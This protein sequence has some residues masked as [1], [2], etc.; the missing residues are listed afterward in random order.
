MQSAARAALNQFRALVARRGRAAATAGTLPVAAR[1]RHLSTTTTTGAKGSW[2]PLDERAVVDRG[3]AADDDVEFR[4]A[5]PPA[6]PR[7]YIV[8]LVPTALNE[9][10]VDKSKAAELHHS[11]LSSLLGSEEEA[12]RC[13]VR[14]FAY[15]HAFS[16][17]L[18]DSQARTISDL[19]GV[20]GACP[21]T[22]HSIDDPTME[23]EV[24]FTEQDK[25]DFIEH[26]TVDDEDDFTENSIDD[27][28]MEMEDGRWRWRNRGP[29]DN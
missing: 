10:D 12:V 23:D 29:R 13:M 7:L 25:D 20:L 19:P 2:S 24:D 6:K 9:A 5:D 27:P 3:A 17:M 4:K 21:N 8:H 18:T 15:L 26:P 28:T 14:S 1:A 11:I 16:A 22:E